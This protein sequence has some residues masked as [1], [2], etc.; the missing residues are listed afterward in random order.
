[1]F[2]CLG[3]MFLSW[4]LFFLFGVRKESSSYLFGIVLFIYNYGSIYTQ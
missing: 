1:M 2:I 3:A 4:M